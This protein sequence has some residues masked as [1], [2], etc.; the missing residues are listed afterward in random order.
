MH[1][2][3]RNISEILKSSK[4]LDT[5]SLVFCSLL[6]FDPKFTFVQFQIFFIK[7]VVPK[8]Y[9]RAIHI[10][11]N[12]YILV[13][14]GTFWYNVLLPGSNGHFLIIV[15]VFWYKWLHSSTKVYVPVQKITFIENLLN[16]FP[17]RLGYFLYN[18]KFLLQMSA[19]QNN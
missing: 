6:S 19:A 5:T 3:S 18:E 4:R 7:N 13:Q 1:K 17:S 11:I 15:C 9:P 10:G 2:C 14:I 16:F 8:K 12:G